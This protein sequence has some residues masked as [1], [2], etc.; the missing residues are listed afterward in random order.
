MARY[1]APVE[2]NGQIVGVVCANISLAEIQKYVEG[3]SKEEKYYGVYTRK[4]TNIA[5]GLNADFI[6][7]RFYDYFPMTEAESRMHLMRIPSRPATT[8]RRARALI[9]STASTPGISKG[10]TPSG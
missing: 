4:G 7:K 5:H 6:L 10:W 9:Q 1:V 8:S 2:V 3:I